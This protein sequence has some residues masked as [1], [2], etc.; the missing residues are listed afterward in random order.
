MASPFLNTPAQRRLLQAIAGG[1]ATDYNVVY[2][3]GRF[4]DFSDHPRKA[5]PITSGPNAGK[6]SS[7]AG[8]YQFLAPTWDETA[9]ELGLKDFSPESQDAAAWHLAAK[10]Y[11]RKTG[12]DLLADLQA[13]RTQDIAPA[14][15]GVWTSIP[16]GI[17]PNKATAGFDARLGGQGTTVASADPRPAGAPMGLLPEAPVQ[18]AAAAPAPGLLG[19]TAQN[20][21]LLGRQP[22]RPEEPMFDITPSPFPQRRRIDPRQMM[23]LMQ[24]Q[25][26]FG[27]AF[28]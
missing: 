1:E 24:G 27:G 6:T 23:A 14:L 3:G 7:A 20:A 4:T 9:R 26:R 21:G 10:T 22:A 5:V 11:E 16:G 12:R 8:L 13:G 28:S 18:T 15:A 17:E 19:G 2:G 25:P